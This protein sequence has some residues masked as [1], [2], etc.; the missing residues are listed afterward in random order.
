M[1]NYNKAVTTGKLRSPGVFAVSLDAD[2]RPGA[3]FVE[4]AGTDSGY[5]PP[6]LG[7]TLEAAIALLAQD[8]PDRALPFFRNAAGDQPGL[9]P[10]AAALAMARALH[11]TGASEEALGLLE[12]AARVQDT[13]WRDSR[14]FPTLAALLEL[15]IAQEIDDEPRRRALEQRLLSGNLPIPARAA[16]PIMDLLVDAEPRDVEDL[17]RAAA[18]SVSYMPAR[19]PRPGPDGSVLFAN[20]H[21]GGIPRSIDGGVTWEPTIDVDTDVHEVLAHPTRP[22]V[23]MA[24][25]AAGLC[26]SRDS[27][28]T[29][30]V[31]C[32]GLHSAY[33]SAIA[34]VGDDVLVAASEGH[35]AAEGGI[36]R[37]AVDDPA[38]LTTL[39]GGMPE[40]LNGIAETNCI[41]TSGSTVVRSSRDSAS[42]RP[43]TTSCPAARSAA[44]S[45]SRESRRWL[46]TSTGGPVVGASG[47]GVSLLPEAMV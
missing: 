4:P 10:P 27:G 34:F 20:V 15:R 30:E 11:R 8:S 42:E 1:M 12:D 17:L 37:R 22:G 35:F 13:A 7:G 38:P 44:A 33:C 31:E 21:V 26:S 24:A 47:A 36:Y 5:Q 14:P 40:W 46:R 45:A 16:R 2:G 18:V 43:S 32:A 25:A 29:W 9:L 28:A 3:P 6:D 41:A 23:V 19:G 39:G